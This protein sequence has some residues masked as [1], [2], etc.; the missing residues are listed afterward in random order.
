MPMKP[1]CRGPLRRCVFRHQRDQYR[2]LSAVDRRE[3]G[4]HNHNVSGT[5]SQAP[6][7]ESERY[8]GESGGLKSSNPI[9]EQDEDGE[10]W[11]ACR[12]ES[13]EVISKVELTGGGPP[14]APSLVSVLWVIGGAAKPILS[15]QAQT[16]SRPSSAIAISSR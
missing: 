11:R 12:S 16:S 3:I 8:K 1:H 9:R 2:S 13:V 4:K 7:K 5:A 14:F 15:R 10:R 6:N